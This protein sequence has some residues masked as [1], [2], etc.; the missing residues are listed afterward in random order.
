VREVYVVVPDGID[1]P[2]RPSGGNT[3]DRHLCDELGAHGWSVRERA[4]AGF[5]GRPDAASFAALEGTLRRVPDDGVVL[6]DGLIASTAPEVL[7]P[8]ASRLRLVVLVHMPLGHRPP[9]DDARRREGAVLA[10]AATVTTS[11]WARRRL[12]ELYG[13]PAHRVSVAEPGAPAAEPAG[14][15][16]TGGA[17]LCVGAVTFAKGHDV[18]LDAL[19]T[20][21]ALSWHCTCVGSLD[22]DPAFVESLRRRS[23]DGGLDERVSFPGPRAGADLDRS[24]ASADLLMHPSR[25]ETYGLV[26]TEALAHGLPVVA[27]DVGGLAEALGEGADGTRPGLLV[28]PEDPGALGDALRVWLGDAELRVRLRRA[29][30]E[31]RRSLPK[32]STTASAVARVLAEASR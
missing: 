32:W 20:I 11:A 8:Q 30:G 16:A 9:G 31:R 13:L 4:V 14:G 21:S 2:G 24:Y 18:L 23:L 28:A 19:G 27:A 1:D 5:W 7:L 22:R 3:Y 26:V 25:A 17:V 6:L 10:A 15:T 12:I 29:A